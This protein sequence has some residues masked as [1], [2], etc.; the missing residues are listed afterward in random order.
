MST[1]SNNSIDVPTVNSKKYLG[2]TGVRYVQMG[3]ASHVQENNEWNLEETV[4][5]AEHKFSTILKTIA[6]DITNVDKLLKTLETQTINQIRE[7][8]KN[9]TKNLSTRF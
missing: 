8:Y 7:E 6:M 5:Q 9:Y 4:R 1:N 3:Q 2:A